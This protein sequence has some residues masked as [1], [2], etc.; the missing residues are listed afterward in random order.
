MPRFPLVLSALLVA[1]GGAESEPS[2][3]PPPG[4]T[5]PPTGSVAYLSP[6]DHLVRTSLAIRGV[7]PSAEDVRRVMA[8]PSTLL[9]LVDTYLEDPRFG[10]TIRTLHNEALLTRV[11][12]L[13][14]PIEPLDQAG[15][16]ETSRSVGDEPLR[17]IEHVVMNDLPYGEILT[18]D[19][20]IVDEPTAIIYGYAFDPTGPEFQLVP[21]PPGRPAAGILTTDGF[22]QRYPSPGYNFNRQRA[23]AVSSAIL[24][25]DFLSADVVIDASVDLSDPDAVSRA[26]VENPACAACHQNLDPI[27]SFFFG[28]NRY[29]P[30]PNSIRGYPL[31]LYSPNNENLWELATGRAPALFGVEGGNRLSD[32]GRLLTENPRFPTCTAQRFWSFFN[33][34]PMEEVALAERDELAAVLVDSGWSAKAL[35]RAIVFSD[36]FR[37][38]HATEDTDLVGL[39]RLRPEQL[40]PMMEDLTGFYW[41]SEIPTRLRGTPVGRVDVGTDVL[42]ILAGGIDSTTVTTRMD[43]YNATSSLVLRAYA[44]EAA[45]HV[46]A[47]DLA[48]DSEP[49]LLTMVNAQDRDPTLIRLQLSELFL[50]LFAERY[51]ATDPEIDETYAVFSQVLTNGG[52]PERAWKVTLT[53]LLQDVRIAY[54]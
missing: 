15:L 33:D 21:F 7:R 47:E 4:N 22:N 40:G 23:N 27:G 8:E 18:A 53:A 14:P 13:Y 10:E 43:T 25:F 42:G 37:Q 36:R 12:R 38:S 51:E 1:C 11:L 48:T 3:S 16:F 50:R 39:R 28:W 20:T 49:R 32:L 31:D 46:V 17:I 19:Y 2:E 24:C 6:E 34:V 35:V 26:V 30:A 44:A 41:E 5:P 45:D 54:Y 29:F 9:A 52:T